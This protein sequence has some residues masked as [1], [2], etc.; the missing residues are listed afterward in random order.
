MRRYVALV[1]G[2]AGVVTEPVRCMI[3]R[4]LA[5]IFYD[6]I[7]TELRKDFLSINLPRF[8]AACNVRDGNPVVPDD[9]II[10]ATDLARFCDRWMTIQSF[11]V[12]GTEKWHPVT[13]D[14]NSL[15]ATMVA[16]LKELGEKHLT[17]SK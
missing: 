14:M 13:A 7:P 16:E 6:S 10:E 1:N 17:I 3:A 4:Q 8:L 12:P 2:L 15:R 5:S 9:L 11:R